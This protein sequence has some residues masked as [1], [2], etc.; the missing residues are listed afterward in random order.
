MVGSSVEPSS[1][2]T[3]WTSTT[4]CRSGGADLLESI[5]H[6]RQV[7]R[8]DAVAHVCLFGALTRSMRTDRSRARMTSWKVENHTAS[9]T[10]ARRTRATPV[11]RP[12][13]ARST[14]TSPL[15]VSNVVHT[16]VHMMLSIQPCGSH[17]DAI[18]RPR[19]RHATA[20][21]PPA[22]PRRLVAS[23]TGAD[24]PLVAPSSCYATVCSRNLGVIGLVSRLHLR[25]AFPTSHW[26]IE[27]SAAHHGRSGQGGLR[28][29]HVPTQQPPPGQEA[30]LQGTA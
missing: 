16:I 13:R 19:A 10:W 11:H 14:C 23:S 27:S 3:I 21:T 26:T 18:S 15:A 30:R 8:Q 4:N 2:S 17:V 24:S 12:G 28:E 1:G 9:E 7:T 20:G 6:Q 29:A 5:P 25:R 22:H